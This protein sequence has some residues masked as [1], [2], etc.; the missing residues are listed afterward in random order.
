MDE[1]KPIRFR[2][3]EVVQPIGKFY[4]GTMKARDVMDVCY[5]DVRRI[6]ERNVEVLSGIQ[7]PLSPARVKELQQYV[8]TV[9]ASFPTSIILAVRP[10]HAE[11]DDGAGEMCLTRGR[12]VAKIID[13]QHRIAGLEALG[14]Q[15]FV[16]PVIIFVG[17]DIEDQAMLFATINLKQTKVS[18]S[19]AF[20]LY[21]YAKTRSPQKSCH[22]V[23]R[24][25]NDR[26]DSPLF[27]M[28]KLLGVATGKPNETLTQAAVVEAL[29]PLITENAM[30][31]RDWLR[32]GRK[33]VAGEN[34][35]LVLRRMFIEGKD[36]EIARVVWNY[37]EAVKQRWPTAWPVRQSGN[38]LNRTTGLSA[39]VSILQL[40]LAQER[41][42]NRVVRVEEFLE[43]LRRSKLRDA[44]LTAESFAPGG[45]G[46]AALTRSLR[47]AIGL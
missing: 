29:L 24:L 27:G 14:T 6:E 18:K 30:R 39:L 17:M 31:D 42:A 38:I 28:I 3:A 22:E 26:E 5:A 11:F 16:L 8:L 10:E 20:D 19:L 4:C 40:I 7:R 21:A 15:E 33:P 36:A 47:E 44:D 13:G 2:A 9:D 1:S 46:R 34:S 32:R 23:V 37:F 25:L 43:L 41:F 35:R 12:E 45:T